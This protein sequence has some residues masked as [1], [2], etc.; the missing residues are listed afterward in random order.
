MAITGFMMWNPIATARYLPGE[1]MPAAKAVH[2]TSTTGGLNLTDYQAT[3]D[4]GVVVPG[5]PD[6][7][8]L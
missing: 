2:G 8:L 6:S 7:S 1:F 4:A 5:D 3:M